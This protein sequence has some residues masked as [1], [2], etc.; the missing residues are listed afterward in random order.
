MAT[1]VITTTTTINIARL[2][3][4]YNN[5]KINKYNITALF[6]KFNLSYYYTTIIVSST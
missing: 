4:P 5:E 2:L 6:F 1:I 3:R